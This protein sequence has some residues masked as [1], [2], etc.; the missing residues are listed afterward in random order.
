M[1]VYIHERSDWPRF[2]WDQAGLAGQLGAVRHRQGRLIGR[3]EALGFRLR[4][5]AV[6]GILT[7]DVLKSS[8]I[9]GEILDS[10]QVRSSLARRLG[11]DLGALIPADRQ[12]EG[13]VEMMLDA[14]QKYQ[15][16]LTEGR[17]FGWHAALFPTGLG[18]MRRIR[19]GAWRDDSTGPMQ[20]VSG[21][22]GRERVHFLA[23]DADRLPAEMAMFLDWFN[24]PDTAEPVLNA[25][26]AHQWFVTIHTF[27]D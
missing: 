10:D 18:G 17:L 16:P 3:M 1:V 2:S 26:L 8:E 22:M 25:A 15:E 5:E 11:L 24:G 19:V 20:V 4:D 6:L 9:E 23:P 12:V 13:V 27:E 21:P 14:T 7:Q